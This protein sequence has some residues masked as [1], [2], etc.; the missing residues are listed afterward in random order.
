MEHKKSKN[1]KIFITIIILILTTQFTSIKAASSDYIDVTFTPTNEPPM[2]LNEIPA[3]ESTKLKLK[4]ICSI[5]VIDL[6]G[7]PMNIYWYE[8]TTGSWVL[9]HKNT[10]VP[11]GTYQWTFVQAES[12]SRKYWWKVAVNDSSH[13][14][15]AIF[16]FTTKYKSSTPN[17]MPIAKITGPDQGYVNQ[18]LIFYAYDSYDSDGRITGYCWDFNNDG[19]FDTDWSDEIYVIRKYSKPGNYTIKLQV[20][21]TMADTATATHTITILQLEPTQQLPIAEANGPYEGYTNETINFS[22]NGSYDQHGIIVNYT[23]YLGDNQES[24]KANPSHTYSKPGYYLVILI[25]RDNENLTNMDIAIV[26]ITDR[27]EMPVKERGLYLCIP[28]F[29]ILAII[30]TIIALLVYKKYK[31]KTYNSS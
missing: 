1:T 31:N 5:D 20:K 29:L 27:T 30:V 6:D 24:Y 18:T 19:L 25:V 3:N 13:N 12:Y 15:T 26:N 2:I 23:W 10:L 28:L 16:H 9:R 8:N 14:I 22:S 4:P 11:D 7:N 21:D 17:K